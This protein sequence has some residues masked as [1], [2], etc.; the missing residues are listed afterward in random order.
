M[1]DARACKKGQ[2]LVKGRCKTL[3]DDDFVII[4]NDKMKDWSSILDVAKE[5]ARK[6]AI[7]TGSGH[8]IYQYIATFEGGSGKENR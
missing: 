3:S 8:S 1:K 6:M 7:E 2:V 5:K 4:S